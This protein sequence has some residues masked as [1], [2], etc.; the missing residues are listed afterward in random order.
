MIIGIAALSKDPSELVRDALGECIGRLC[1][2]SFRY[3]EITHATRTK[4]KQTGD[5]K[6]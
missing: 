4:Q 6:V 5:A 1:L 2:T 3:L